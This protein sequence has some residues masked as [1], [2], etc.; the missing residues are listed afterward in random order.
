MSETSYDDLFTLENLYIAY[1]KAKADI[2]F[3]RSITSVR[4]FAEYEENLEENLAR[5]K[6]QLCSKGEGLEWFD[7]LDFIGEVAFV[8]K[9][10][11]LP[12]EA[13]NSPKFFASNAKD[14]WNRIFNLADNNPDAIQAEFRPVSNFNVNMHIVCALWINT[15]GEKID[16]FLD[17]SALG[18][19]LR[20][21]AGSEIYHRTLWQSFEPY[22]QSYK[23]WRDDGFNIIRREIGDGKKVVAL[24]LDFRRF[25]HKIDPNFLLDNH[26]YDLLRRIDED[27]A[28][29]VEKNHCFTEKLVKAFETWG[30][31]VPGYS[32]GQPVGLPVG[33]TASRIIAN[34]I[35]LEFDITIQ[36]NILPIYYARYVD[37][38][39]L[40]LRDN[41][42]FSS[43]KD[44]LDWIQGRMDKL[45]ISSQ[46]NCLSVNLKYKLLSQIEFQSDK[47]RVFL[48]DN[49][50]LLDAI[51]SKI[52]EVA[53]EWR[54]LP[55]L[56]QMER[57]AAARVLSTS[58][59]GNSD[60][61]SLRK[62]ETLQLKRLGFAILLRNVDATA[63]NLPPNEWKNERQEFYEFAIRHVIAPGKL[64]ELAD[65][66][67][68]LI[69]IAVFCKDWD[70]AR[71]LVSTVQGIYSRIR[72]HSQLIYM[73][74]PQPQNIAEEIW[75]GFFRHL[76]QA[77]QEAFLKSILPLKFKQ[78]NYSFKILTKQIFER[79]IE[80]EDSFSKLIDLAERIFCRDLARNPF[81]SFLLNEYSLDSTFDLD[82]PKELPLEFINW[83]EK[84]IS[85]LNEIKGINGHTFKK[86][87]IP[88]TAILF[89]TRPLGPEDISLLCPHKSDNLVFVMETLNTVRGTFYKTDTLD[90]QKSSDL[91]KKVGKGGLSFHPRIAVT[92]FLTEPE[93]W[94]SAAGKLPDLS[95]ERFNRLTILCNSI[96]KTPKN[97]RPNYVLFPELSIPSR[98]LRTIAETLLQSGIS[99]I[100]GEEYIHHG[101]NNVDSAARLF[102]TDNRLGYRSWCAL[103]QLKGKAAHHEKDEL[104]KKFGI[105][106][107]PSDPKL[108]HKFIFD[109]FGFRFGLLICSEL[110]DMKYRLNFRGKIDSLFVLSWNQDLE[111]FAALVDASALDIHCY[112]ALVNNRMFG[113]SRVRIPHTN[114]W[115]RDAVRVKGGLADYFVV[116]ELDIDSLRDFQSHCEPP[117]KPFKPFPEGFE[118][119]NERRV[120]PGAGKKFQSDNADYS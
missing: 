39:F 41:G 29:L 17:Q 57:S 60:G 98:W 20:R 25:Y 40:V 95:A 15:V 51:K 84:I 75:D 115:L 52:D 50:D 42:T 76:K 111:S 114:S 72:E 77:F 47:Q 13:K 80:D 38:I 99:V 56:K 27:K 94:C 104:R 7:D 53:S 73:D 67:P 30:R 11:S 119:P 86:N 19:R 6:H 8:P 28:T 18:S 2:Y 66:L 35:L 97:A 48:I 45:I 116:A 26:F 44:V 87:K 74:L 63:D 12:E 85:F 105:E 78:I 49:A 107:K 16:S 82:L 90:A 54:L 93:S 120:I 113:D 117:E 31:S 58:R 69:S 106:L 64:F 83:N 110:T 100:A 5:L 62:A 3:D 89:P 36:R 1:R 43:G 24:T 32:D 70:Y 71:R 10:L 59:D 92:S 102:L 101:R 96:L 65:Y 68:R 88:T 91:Y 103:A 33:A 23:K 37:D 9:K 22:F 109:H 4:M 14:N 55:D 61:D 108:T 46:N 79:A 112:V 34:A 21:I 81:K 118:I